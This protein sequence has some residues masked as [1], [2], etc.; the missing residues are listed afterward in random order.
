MSLSNNFIKKDRATILIFFMVILIALAFAIF[1][2]HA[3]EDWYITYRA[4]KNLALG[5]GLVFTVG[6]K[7]HTFTSPMEFYF[8]PCSSFITFNHSDD[9]VLW[10][11]RIFGCLL[12]GFSGVLLLRIAKENC[13]TS[14]SIIFLLY[15]VC[16]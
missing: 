13:F 4:S 10:L 5:H 11:F 7:L 16:F 2:Q 6:E 1:T 3:W 12:L 8:L 14:I 15:D 9:L